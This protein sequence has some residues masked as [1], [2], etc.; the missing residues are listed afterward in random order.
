VGSAAGAVQTS[1]SG[2]A[3]CSA[4]KP[5]R[6]M[7]ARQIA[8]WRGHW[9]SPD[10]LDLPG[11]PAP[12]GAGFHGKPVTS[13]SDRLHTQLAFW[14]RPGVSL[15]MVMHSALA[16]LLP[17]SPGHRIHRPGAFGEQPWTPDRIRQSCAASEVVAES[18]TTL[19]RPGRR[20]RPSRHRVPFE[21]LPSH[22]PTRS[23]RRT[24][25]SVQM[26]SF[27]MSTAP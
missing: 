24:A 7:A 6:F 25:C 2:S 18:F 12:A 4:P 27:K 1:A 23:Q 26:L 13:R 17:G 14:P 9:R 10:Q 20:P 11:M 19:A 16:V 15:F 8:Y 3:K 5:I 21:R 22:Q